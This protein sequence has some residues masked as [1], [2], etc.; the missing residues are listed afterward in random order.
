MHAAFAL[1]ACTPSW[2]AN[3]GSGA[4][5]RRPPL[6]SY[7]Q[8]GN[9]AHRSREHQPRAASGSSQAALPKR[10]AKSWARNSG[11]RLPGRD[12]PS[13]VLIEQPVSQS[14]NSLTGRKGR[15]K[16]RALR[17]RNPAQRAQHRAQQRARKRAREGTRQG[18]PDGT[19]Q[20]ARHN[21]CLQTVAATRSTADPQ[22][23]DERQ[24]DFSQWKCS[25]RLLH[26]LDPRL[27]LR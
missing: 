18:A 7:A 15:N 8:S 6:A 24:G 22:L 19:R 14:C 2:Y 11:A 12:L 10:S 20:G 27:L 23:L 4:P 16:G 25:P 21:R 13:R 9:A 26:A 5:G 3:V 1:R 17:R